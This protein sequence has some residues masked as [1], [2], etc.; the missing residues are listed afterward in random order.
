MLCQGCPDDE[1]TQIQ[2]PAGFEIKGGSRREYLRVKLEVDEH[3][4]ISLV[5]FANQGSGILSSL[6]WADGLAEVEIGAKISK[7]DAVKVR[8]L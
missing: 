4:H 3:G 2:V 6:S 8:L 7:G 1:L 5:N